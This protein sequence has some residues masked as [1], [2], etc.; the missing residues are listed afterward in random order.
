VTAA[1]TC[2]VAGTPEARRLRRLG[3]GAVLCVMTGE[4]GTTTHYA[5][6]VEHA[7][8]LLGPFAAE[9]LAKPRQTRA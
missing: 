3:A 4:D 5:A 7:L 2:P 6:R 9:A 8:D 1:E